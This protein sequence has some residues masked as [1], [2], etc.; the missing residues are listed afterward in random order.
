MGSCE[1]R[2]SVTLWGTTQ[3]TTL[4]TV[5]STITKPDAPRIT[6][7]VISTTCDGDGNC[8]PVARPTIIVD[9]A[10]LS[11]VTV[12]KETVVTNIIPVQT[13]YHPCPGATTSPSSAVA[14]ATATATEAKSE[15]TSASTPG[16]NTT[17]DDSLTLTNTVPSP[18]RSNDNERTTTT[19]RASLTRSGDT[20]QSTLIGETTGSLGTTDEGSPPLV[21]FSSD[22]NGLSTLPSDSIALLPSTTLT[23]SD[24]NPTSTGI[25]SSEIAGIVIGS[26]AGMIFLGLFIL[27]CRGRRDRREGGLVHPETYWERRF[28]ELEGVVEKPASSPGAGLNESPEEEGTH[29]LHVRHLRHPT[30]FLHARRC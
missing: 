11:F 10:D 28:Q 7:L 22:S 27:R 21:P 4:T 13:R 30:P 9:D 26:L 25:G 2:P 23:H 15:S 17:P 8:G 16:T 6:S 12:T 20:T 5:L 29:Q 19:S 18:T 24:L 3:V 1:E 14:T